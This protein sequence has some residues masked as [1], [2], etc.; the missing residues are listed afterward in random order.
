M[1]EIQSL[2]ET[3]NVKNKGIDDS[4]VEKYKNDLTEK[5]LDYLQNERGLSLD[6]IKHFNLGYDKTR[7]AISIPLYKRGVLVAI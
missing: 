1:S 7:K 4:L 5:G 3:L 2:E 6:T